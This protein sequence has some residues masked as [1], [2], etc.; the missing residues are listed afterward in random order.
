LD[1]AGNHNCYLNGVNVGAVT[2]G[3]LHQYI[4]SGDIDYIGR[5]DGF[6]FGDIGQVQIYKRALSSTEITQN[7]NSLRGRYS[8]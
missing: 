6:W 1:A 4:N 3:T 7:F 5:A 8:I 2:G